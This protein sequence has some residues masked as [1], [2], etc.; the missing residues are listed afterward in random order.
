MSGGEGVGGQFMAR[1]ILRYGTASPDSLLARNSSHMYA[2]RHALRIFESNSI[3]TMIPKNACSSLRLSIA[4]ANGVLSG[5]EDIEWIHLNNTTFAA[6]LADLMLARFTFVVLRCPYARLASC[7]LDKFVGNSPETAKYAHALGEQVSIEDLSFRDFCLS[8][9]EANMLTA[10][11]HWAPQ[12]NFLVY[13]DYDA[14]YCV[15]RFGDAIA[16]LPEKAGLPVIDTRPVT[17]HGLERF[18]HRPRSEHYSDATIRDLRKL[19]ELGECPE[20]ASLYDD[21]IISIIQGLYAED[22]TL[23]NEKFPGLSLFAPTSETKKGRIYDLAP[24]NPLY[25]T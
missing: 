4:V 7:F 16:A 6:S 1:R 17:R 5:A 15:E 11:I 12:V 18:R 13:K 25:G 23:Y 24:R 20:P 9:G 19:R 21:K 2:H 3:Y 14:Y 22:L 10:N 8:L